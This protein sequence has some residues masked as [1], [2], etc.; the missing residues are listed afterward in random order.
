MD[1]IISLPNQAS[2][3]EIR[4]RDTRN[5]LVQSYELST[6][7]FGTVHG[8]FQLSEGAMVGDYTIEVESLGKIIQ[9]IFKVQDYKKPDIQAVLET[10]SDQYIDGEDIN[11]KLNVKY[12]FGEPVHDADVSLM[13]YNLV[14]ISYWYR[15]SDNDNR[16]DWTSGSSVHKGHLSIENG[17]LEYSIP[18]EIDHYGTQHFYRNNIERRTVAIEAS[19]DDGSGQYVSTYKIIEI[20]NTDIELNLDV[21]DYYKSPGQSFAAIASI[22]SISSIPRPD[23]PIQLSIYKYN[24]ESREYDELVHSSDLV[25]GDDGEVSESITLERKGIYRFELVGTDDFGNEIQCKRWIYVYEEG[26]PWEEELEDEIRIQANNTTFAPGETATFIIES[27]FDSDAL[28]SVQRGTTRRVKKVTLTAPITNVDLEILETDAPN[29]FVTINA[30][31]DEES[32]VR[33]FY[34][35]EEYLWARENLVDSQLHYDTIELTIPVENKELSIT[36]TPDKEIYRPREQATFSISVTDHAGNPVSAELSLAFVDDAIFSL[37]EDLSGPLFDAFYTPRSHEVL[38]YNSMG[39]RRWIDFYG[40]AGGGGGGPDFPGRPRSDFPD[41]AAWI[42]VL[43]T[44]SK[45][46]AEMTIILPDTLTTWRLTAKAIT[47][48]TKVGEAMVTIQTKQEVVVRPRVP[49]VLTEGDEVILSA[50]VQNYDERTREFD[51]LLMNTYFEVLD[52]ALQT[53]SL[54]PGDDGTISWRV[55]ANQAGTA[56]VT[57]I[58]DD[59]DI[60]D[61][62]EVSIPVQEITIP[63]VATHV[64]QFRGIF[65]TTIQLPEENLDQSWIELVLNR[66]I[67]DNLLEGL[68]Y[69]TGFPYGCVEQT[70][71]RAFPNAMVARAFHQL[72][73][74]APPSLSDLPEKINS[75]LQRLYGYQHLDGGWGWWHDDDSHAYQTA[76]VVYGLAM[77]SEAGYEVNQEVIK[78]G[79]EWL[80][81]NLEE[82]DD[83]MKAY[84]LY[85][86]AI[87]GYGDVPQTLEFAA[88]L[89]EMDSFSIAAV[90]LALHELEEYESALELAMLLEQRAVVDESYVH[91]PIKTGDSSFYRQTM[92]SEIRDTALALSALIKITPNH[93]YEAR[94]VR[95]LMDQRDSLGWGDTHRTSYAI[96]ALTD[97]LL[98]S[99]YATHTTNYSVNVN[100]SEVAVGSLGPKAPSVN[101]IVSAE[102]LIPGAN[103]IEITQ[104]GAGQIYYVINR[105]I[106]KEE[107]DLEP[108]GNIT[109]ERQL[110]SKT[111]SS[112]LGSLQLGELVKIKLTVTLPRDGS[113]IIVEDMLPGGFE[114]LNE[115]LSITS[116]ERTLWGEPRFAWKENGYNHKE[117][118]ADRVS[119]FFTEL[120]EGR[121][122]VTYLARVHYPGTFNAMPVQAW[123]M[124]DS[125]LW[126]RSASSNVIVDHHSP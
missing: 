28:L 15:T 123:A 109:V 95:W 27:T 21:G 66:S 76:W 113:F 57:M 48:D 112:A 61:A 49:R 102:Q 12:F 92:S 41:T 117:I 103:T 111:N 85:S 71:S 72:G 80:S 101:I 51:V 79:A 50:N 47:K 11:L 104:Q 26:H 98:A 56:V 124:Y 116:H 42:P 118:R 25:T 86:M 37:S 78:R 45:G 120:S 14:P 5:N 121:H 30:Y 125:S 68:D 75:G 20:F 39:A 23:F 110:L 105:W 87:A 90:A 62:V 88:N 126:G 83:R 58:A 81:D 67:A 119:F 44:D 46:R 32:S 94:I 108:A 18:A 1:A 84:A 16:Y 73:V 122:T 74:A 34:E 40:G 9:Q 8:E 82:M 4:I 96:L 64:G 91:W 89:D 24:V 29:I 65:S 106:Y 19:I 38:T 10:D 69:L 22:S 2:P 59:G 114:A 70:M 100:D 107:A 33:E 6:N 52:P 35:W 93:P 13:M 55:R 7:S 63:E 60:G 115:N 17:I 53:L 97:H 36:L 99:K 43:Q 31:T 77:T 3:V 54:Q